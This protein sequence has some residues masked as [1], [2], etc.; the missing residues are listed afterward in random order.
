MRPAFRI[1]A[2][3]IV[4]LSVAIPSL[5]IRQTLAQSIGHLGEA[6]CTVQA[7]HHSETLVWAHF[8]AHLGGHDSVERGIDAWICLEHYREMSEE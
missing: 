4:A 3:L 6:R 1:A 8:Y 7:E 5:L 2:L